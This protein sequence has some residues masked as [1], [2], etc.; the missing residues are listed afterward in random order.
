M[1]KMLRFKPNSLFG[2]SRRVMLFWKHCENESGLKV[3]YRKMA[4]IL[5]G[6]AKNP[7]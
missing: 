4:A 3:C 5:V 7:Q 2:N 6:L 1:S